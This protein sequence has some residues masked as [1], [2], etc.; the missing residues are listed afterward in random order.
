MF[1]NSV[2]EFLISFIANSTICFSLAWCIDQG[3]RSSARFRLWVWNL[4]MLAALG[5]SIASHLPDTT[6]QCLLSQPT[7]LYV[8][9]IFY[10]SLLS[11]VGGSF[12]LA[13]LLTWCWF[14][15]VAFGLLAWSLKFY[16]IRSALQ[17]RTPTH[18]PKLLIALARARE[19]LGITR[20]IHLSVHH[21]FTS[22]VAISANEICLSQHASGMDELHLQAILGHELAHLERKDHLKFPLIA[23]LRSL[24]WFAPLWALFESTR[25]HYIEEICDQFGAQACGTPKHMASALVAVAQSSR[26]QKYFLPGLNHRPGTLPRRVKALLN[27]KIRSPRNKLRTL[28]WVGMGTAALISF[29]VLAPPLTMSASGP[30]G[31]AKTIAPN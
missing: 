24:F 2:A 26:A 7:A 28:L 25:A 29:Q 15:G 23:I 31:C 27:S 3:L 30:S 9:H 6:V 5:L 16:R 4:A 21:R 20:P 13:T 19:A 12:C 14:C 22:P 8:N 1:Y 11:P 18:E 10:G 17:Q